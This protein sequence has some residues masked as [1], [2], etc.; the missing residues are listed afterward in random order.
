M[1]QE[2]ARL[3]ETDLAA[4]T[5]PMRFELLS[6]AKAGEE[7]DLEEAFRFS[8]HVRFE[9]EDWRE[10]ADLDLNFNAQ[11]EEAAERFGMLTDRFGIPW[12]I[13]CAPAE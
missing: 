7:A 3:I 13:N 2:V 6:G 4:Y 10:A 11:C 12:M 8:R 1:K 9:T 5:C